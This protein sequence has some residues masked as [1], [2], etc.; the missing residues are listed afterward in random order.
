MDEIEKIKVVWLC[1]FSNAFVHE[2][3]DLRRDYMIDLILRITHKP[4]NTN[5]PEFAN[6]IT[7][8]IR[9]FNKFDDVELHVVS[10]YPYLKGSI[11][12]FE[13]NGIY[14]HFFQSEENSL[15]TYLYRRLFRPAVIKIHRNGKTISSIIKKIK[16]DIIH[17]FGAENPEYATGFL[18]NYQAIIT[19]AQLQTL[20]SDPDFKKNY[21]RDDRGFA[22]KTDIEKAVIRKADYVGTISP[23]YRRIVQQMIK[24]DAVFLNTGLALKDS[25]Y[26]EDCEKMF[27]FVYFA[28]NI[29]KAA[30]LALEAFGMAYQRDHTITLDIIGGYD[31]AMMLMLESIAE[32]YGIKDAIS[33]EG[34]LPTHEDVLKQIRKSRFAL[35]PLRADLTSGTIREAMSNGL[36]IIT[37]DTG[38]LGTQKL[39]L[40]RKN[41]LLSPIGD[42]LAMANN[43]LNLITD[44][45]LAET[46]R[47]NGFQTRL[48]ARS[49]EMTA[50]RYVDAYK[51]CMANKRNNVPLP[52]V[53]TEV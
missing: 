14:Y 32:K 37:T 12:E 16:P 27:D 21:S 10:P 8:G 47:Q 26:T 22:Y 36:P 25:I 2:K 29:N 3:L 46:M 49:N 31:N 4:A 24:A 35:L 30:D 33:I 28:A 13:A 44:K 15:K 50:Q 38:E 45:E 42:A 17:L 11:Q 41:A 9:E 18:E 39:N 53:I 34:L 19:I 5:V 20:L 40:Q 1:H 7:N 48:E 43:M 51:A 52:N 6:W 23:K